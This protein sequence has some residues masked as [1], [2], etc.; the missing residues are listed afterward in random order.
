MYRLMGIVGRLSIVIAN[1]QVDGHAG[2]LIFKNSGKYFYRI[3]L[4]PLGH[5]GTLSGPP[6]LHLMGYEG[7]I[8][9]KSCGTAIN[10]HT[11][12]RAV[13]LAI[14]GYSE[15]FTECVADPE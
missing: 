12:G 6:S 13:R 7:F 2:G 11:N 5:D 14:G 4:L 10:D 15:Y 9:S 3:S 8:Y 1:H